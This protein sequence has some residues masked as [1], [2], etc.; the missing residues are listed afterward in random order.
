[1]ISFTPVDH[2]D[3][4][5]PYRYDS[6]QEDLQRISSSIHQVQ[7]TDHQQRST[8]WRTQNLRIRPASSQHE[9]RL[10]KWLSGAFG[11]ERN[12]ST[13]NTRRQ[14][15]TLCN[16]KFRFVMQEAH[17]NKN[18]Q[19]EKKG[20]YSKCLTIWINLTCQFQSIRGG[21]VRIG[22]GYCEDKR[23]WIGDEG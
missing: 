15:W 16:L 2:P 9:R 13:K 18:P 14:S 10:S 4:A 20:L 17:F 6:P 21:Q 7:F 5:K 19:R 12:I 8:T 11:L 3:D 22:R 1:M 23:V